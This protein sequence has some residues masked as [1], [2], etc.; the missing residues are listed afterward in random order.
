M[1]TSNAFLYNVITFYNVKIYQLISIDFV[2]IEN[3][4]IGTKSGI[5]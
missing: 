2:K 1:R 4:G 3:A 5:Y